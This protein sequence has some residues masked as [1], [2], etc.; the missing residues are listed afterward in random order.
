[1]KKTL[2]EFALLIDRELCGVTLALY[3]KS[4]K[5]F[6]AFMFSLLRWY[7]DGADRDKIKE[8]TPE[9]LDELEGRIFT[10]VCEAHLARFR[11]H[12]DVNATA[13]AIPRRDATE[14]SA[15]NTRL[16]L[17]EI[18]ELCITSNRDPVEYGR[19]IWEEFI[20]TNWRDREGHQITNYKSYITKFLIPTIDK[21][22]Q[23]TAALPKGRMIDCD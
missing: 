7:H 10:Y 13:K 18:N 5:K 19:R 4:K 14:P 1:M 2:K 23:E 17:E 16:T 3:K 22:L 11:N 8:S 9:C 21:V 6:T 12:H 20:H 15:N